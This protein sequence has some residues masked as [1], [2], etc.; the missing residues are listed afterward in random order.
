MDGTDYRSIIKEYGTSGIVGAVILAIAVP[1]FLSV[2]LVGKKKAKQ[3]GV[4]VQVSGEA[5]LAMRN[6]RQARLVE[7]PW[8]G[9]TTMAA[10]FEQSC[11]KYWGQRFLGRRKL[12]GR[13]FVTASDGRKFEKLHLGDYQWETYGQVFDRACNFASG[14][15]KLGHDVDTRAA[16]FSETRAE[17]FIAFQGCFRQNVT[18]VTIY[19]SLGDDALIHSL[20][21][22][23][24]STLICDSKQL[25][26]LAA[27][28]SSLKTIRN[29]VYFEDGEASSDSNTSENISN[30]TVFSFSEIEKLGKSNPVLPTL[31]I[32]KDIAVVMYTSGSTGLPKGVMITHGNIVATSAAVMT[33][34]PRLGSDDVY[35]A[36]LPL[37]HVFELAA[38][39][40][41]LTAGATIGYGSAL[42]LTDT[43]NKI[44]KGT[45]GDASMLQPT[46]MA[47][48]PAILDRVREG[49]LKKVD[50]KGGL[51]KQL[52]DIAFKR[53]LAAIEGSWFGAWG[54]EARLW[55]IIIFTQIRSVLGGKIRFMLCGGAPLSGDTQRFI[56]ICMGAPIGQGYGL[57]E[58]FAGAAFSEWDDSSVGRVG[59]PLACCYIKLVS[60]EEGGYTTYD[61]PM[62]RGE[63]V[64]GGCSV[65]SGYFKN[66]AKTNEV[67]KVD[68]KG[69]RWFYT[70]DIGR[71]HPDGCLEIIDRKKDIIKLQHGE[72]I[73]LGKVEAALITSSYVDNIMVYVDPFHNYCVAL[74]VPSHQALKKWAEDS[75]ISH[76]KFSDL[77]NKTEAINEVQ[78]SLSKVA[79]EAKLDKFEIPAKIKLLPDPWTPESGLVTA[80]LKLKR[81][82]LKA[83]FKDELEKLYA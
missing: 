57:T 25:K 41:M 1:V 50:E 32:K 4:H 72:Y 52:F 38:E 45:K 63:V 18:V 19:A 24:V 27:V 66:E 51:A 33:V 28:S 48:V 5:G 8:E 73:S 59:P 79:K 62:P 77:C 11:K 54:L 14:L 26:K 9:A 83:K 6:A 82:Q 68:E 53:R 29:I 67:Y 21:E 2:V 30:W 34:I 7:V 61:K 35:L 76:D 31:P 78:K 70:G 20:N 42:T 36:Y 55:D 47:A 49:V 71:F 10:L 17:W 65:T 40:V 15:V 37:A 46:L 81:E 74:V 39:S 64:I 69:M 23:Q 60:W 22:T 43:S 13:E 12:I 44:K 75:G 56:N 3:R 80:A 16:I 58:T